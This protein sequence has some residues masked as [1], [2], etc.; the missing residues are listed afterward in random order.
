M[1]K[2]QLLLAL[3]AVIMLTAPTPGASSPDVAGI[4]KVLLPGASSPGRDITLFLNRDSGVRRISDYLNDEAP[5]VEVGAWQFDGERV[6]I[7]LSGKE[8]RSYD[9]P[10]AVTLELNGEGLI[11]LPP[12]DGGGRWT[13][14]RF[15]DLA[16]GK[17]PVPYNPATAHEL[18]STKGFAGNYKAFL[19]AASCCGRDISLALN[20]DN[21]ARLRTDFLNG[22][23]AIVDSGTWTTTPDGGVQVEF[24]DDTPPLLLTLVD[25]LLITPP[26][27]SRFGSAGLRLYRFEVIAVNSVEIAE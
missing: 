16:M 5:I 4:Y 11:E 2:L 14:V 8:N 17:T 9:T 23:A 18:I 6:Q 27:D 1:R 7:S 26:D 12:E 22:E 19:P 13:Y 20:V 21:S 3:I 15:E 24:D 25:G 10:V